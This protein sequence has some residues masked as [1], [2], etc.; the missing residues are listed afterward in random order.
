MEESMTEKRYYVDVNEAIID[1][2]TR[3]QYTGVEDI[4]DKLNELY[5]SNLA[6]GE[7]ISKQIEQIEALE[8][9]YF[10]IRDIA[11]ELKK[12]NEQL[13]QQLAHHTRMHEWFRNEAYLLQ[14]KLDN[15]EDE[16]RR[17]KGDV[18]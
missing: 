12:E 1:S 16:I 8:N 15:R 4:A 17:L 11:S 5:T 7:I 10:S 6:Q 18:E 9:D 13:K 2:K 14:N 3:R